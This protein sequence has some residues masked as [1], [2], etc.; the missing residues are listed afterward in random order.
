MKINLIHFLLS[1]ILKYSTDPGSNDQSSVFYQNRELLL[2][3][4]K[5]NFDALPMIS[6]FEGQN[7]Q[8]FN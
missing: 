3:H 8:K 5:S 2:F 1:H 7:S 4:L 6:C